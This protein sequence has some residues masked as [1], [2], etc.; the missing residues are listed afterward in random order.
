MLFLPLVSF[1]VALGRVAVTKASS[2]TA[3]NNCGDTVWL[4]EVYGSFS[5]VY[6]VNAGANAV[7]NQPPDGT[8]VAVNVYTGCSD[9]TA[10]SCTT[11][12][13]NNNGGASPFIRAEATFTGGSVNYDISP[14]YGYNRAI[15]I[16][17]GDAN[18]PGVQCTI[19]SGCPV[20]GP[21]G[22]CYGPCCASADGCLGT[23]N[24]PYDSTPAYQKQMGGKGTNSG[25]YHD[26]CPNAY[27][28]PDDDCANYGDSPD[29]GCGDN[30][31]L[32]ITVCPPG[33]SS[34]INLCSS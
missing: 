2:I 13:V 11:G 23:N 34:N 26:A 29:A 6:A 33:G 20:P 5:Q 15:K 12:G 10:T 16:N 3:V 32:T 22:S 28:F 27:S 18:C 31:D 25:F 30:T 14:L 24:C 8:G 4:H 17:T 19:S 1:A 9:N 7:L 21:D